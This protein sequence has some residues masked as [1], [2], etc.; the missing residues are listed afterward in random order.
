MTHSTLVIYFKNAEGMEN[1]FIN[2]Y[3]FN[4]LTCTDFTVSQH[5]PGLFLGILQQKQ[6]LK[7]E[8]LIGFYSH[9]MQY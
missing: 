8:F 3:A 1:V 5:C 9:M 7:F 4:L 2:Y 6:N